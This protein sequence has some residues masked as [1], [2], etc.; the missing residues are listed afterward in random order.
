MIQP[1]DCPADLFQLQIGQHTALCTL[2]PFVKQ[3]I[4]N[5]LEKG[6]QTLR[7]ASHSAPGDLLG[8]S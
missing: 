5:D 1:G 4:K 7:H 3:P 6:I 8:E 2:Q